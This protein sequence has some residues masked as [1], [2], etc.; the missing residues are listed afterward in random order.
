MRNIYIAI[1]I[2]FVLLVGS[3]KAQNQQKHLVQLQGGF[4]WIGLS[5]NIANTFNVV[6]DIRFSASPALHIE[7]NYFF[8]ERLSLGVGIAYQQISAFY[9][10]YEYE[11]GGETITENI[12]AELTRLNFSA[13]ALFWYNPNST[14][15]LYSGLR[16][17]VS[18]WR[19]DT[20]TGDP[21]FDIDQYINIALGAAFAPQ[22]ILVGG[23]IPINEALHVGGELSIGS[24][25]FI[26]AGVSYAW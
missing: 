1:T 10:G 19:A 23:D 26:S 3:A 7:Y 24:P 4:S 15:R 8:Y 17:G 16:L 21:N 5:A 2:F 9:D 6:D 22:L 18:N 25:Y 14:F 20:N 13:R 12:N 11:S